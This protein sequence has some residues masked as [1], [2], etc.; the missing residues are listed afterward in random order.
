MGSRECTDAQLANPGSILQNPRPKR[1][2]TTEETKPRLVLLMCPSHQR[3]RPTEGRA[4]PASPKMCQERH[5]S[6]S[7]PLG[8][9]PKPPRSP[10]QA[11][12]TSCP[13]IHADTETLAR[14]PCQSVPWQKVPPAQIPPGTRAVLGQH[15]RGHSPAAKATTAPRRGRHLLQVKHFAPQTPPAIP[16]PAP[17][18]FCSPRQHREAGEHR[19]SLTCEQISTHFGRNPFIP[20]GCPGGSSY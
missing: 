15:L 8:W 20:S 5:P 14:A 4:S 13:Q 3:H 10:C 12:I 17:G 18:G 6:T 16:S 7:A 1:S 9:A 19:D 2:Q 11:E